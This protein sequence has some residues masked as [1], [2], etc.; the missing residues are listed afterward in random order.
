MQVQNVDHMFNFT[1]EKTADEIKEACGR[2]LLAIAAKIEERSMRIKKMRDEHKITDAIL[3]DIQEQMRADA[4]RGLAAQYTSNKMSGGG[5]GEEVTV[6]AGVIN[7]ILTE[8]D[9]IGGEKAQAERL[10]L[11]VRNLRP[12][13]GIT[14]NGTTYVQPF[15]LSYDELKFLGF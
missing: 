3:L 15:K 10:N 4:K 2:K 13:S 14:A 8:Q 11:I 1:F 7:F 6:G 12:I 5:T 9:F